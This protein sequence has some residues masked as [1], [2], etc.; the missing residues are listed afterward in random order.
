MISYKD[1]YNSTG[2][3]RQEEYEKWLCEAPSCINIEVLPEMED[4]L[5]DCFESDVGDYEDR[6]YDEW[7][8]RNI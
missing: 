3:N 6:A 4:Y 7:K 5:K 8:D 2:W 1:W